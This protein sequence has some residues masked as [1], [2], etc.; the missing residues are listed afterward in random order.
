MEIFLLYGWLQRIRSCSKHRQSTQ[1]HCCHCPSTTKEDGF[2]VASDIVVWIWIQTPS[3]LLGSPFFKAVGW[4]C[5]RVNHDHS[6][7]STWLQ[8][9]LA[10]LFWQICVKIY[11]TDNFRL[12][13]ISPNSALKASL[14]E[15]R[16]RIIPKII[17]F[18]FIIELLSYIFHIVKYQLYSSCFI[19]FWFVFIHKRRPYC[20]YLLGICGNKR[21]EKEK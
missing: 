16:R 6:N 18:W 10:N 12:W 8:S 17:I 15:Y 5:R 7:A 14:V 1:V 3:L 2:S 21:N 11:I 9:I 4:I 13:D 20:C 19:L